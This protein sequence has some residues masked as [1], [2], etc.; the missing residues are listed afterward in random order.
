MKEGMPGVVHQFGFDAARTGARQAEKRSRGLKGQ[1]SVGDVWTWT[2]L[3]A[4]TK[5]ICSWYVGERKY[6][7]ARAFMEDLKSRLAGRVQLTTDGHQVYVAA[8]GLT[9]RNNI[10]WAQ[11]QK[12][13]RAPPREREVR[14][15]PSVCVG[16][17]T[18]ILRGNPDPDRISTSFV[19]RQNLTMRMRMRRFTRL[20]NGFSKKL[21]NHMAAIAL[22]FLHYN[23]ARPHKTLANPY[24]RTPAMAA[25]VG[26]SRLDAHRDRRAARRVDSASMDL[27]NNRFKLPFFVVCA[28]VFVVLLVEGDLVVVSAT[29]LA[30]CVVC[31]GVIASGRNP[32]WLQSPLDRWEAKKRNR[33]N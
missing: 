12:E 8:V 33:S 14:Y 26:R 23:F 32:R 15:S 17:K 29:L 11:L 21:D 2:A 27:P 16:T 31:I 25:G 1:F 19:E 30:L 10:D 5:L 9:F 24:P 28:A 20:T 22:H 3:C 7:D 6:E 13:Y 4:D 18:P